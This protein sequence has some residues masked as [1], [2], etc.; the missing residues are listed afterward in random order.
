[1][2]MT[3]EEGRAGVIAA[4]EHLRHLTDV[5]PGAY[6]QQASFQLGLY[7][8]ISTSGFEYAYHAVVEAIPVSFYD[9]FLFYQGINRNL[10][11]AT[12]E[13]WAALGGQE[14]VDNFYP[15]AVARNELIAELDAGT[16]TG[17]DIMLSLA[18]TGYDNDNLSV[19]EIKTYGSMVDENPVVAN[20]RYIELPT[21]TFVEE[22]PVYDLPDAGLTFDGLTDDQL[23]FMIAMYVG[24]FSRAPDYDGLEFWANGLAAKMS[25]GQSFDD[26]I[27]DISQSFYDA[28]SRN[29]ELGTDM[30]SA[31][32]VERA[33]DNV[34]GRLPDSGGKQFWTDALD[35]GAT[36]KGHFLVNFINGATDSEKDSTHID[37]LV[38]VSEFM[39][40]EHVSADGNDVRPLLESVLDI[41]DAEQAEAVITDVIEEYGYA[42][43][44][45]PIELTGI[46]TG[47]D[48]A[49][50][51]MMG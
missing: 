3:Y 25:T 33:Y 4:M 11:S 21:P 2:S 47:S 28:G 43:Q 51:L 8:S 24:A 29:G 49:A 7:D 9:A 41:I 36:S 35:S 42:D 14:V 16:I 20:E 23:D 19:D 34:L 1:M 31:E 48:S 15:D 30:S 22:S 13:F 10:P 40:Q 50:D 39:A 46:N 5:E 26:A 45:Q 17:G 32:Y 44:S 38:S 18:I 12:D 37:Q 6:E 27:L